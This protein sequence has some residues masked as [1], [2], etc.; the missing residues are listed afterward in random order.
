MY[1]IM[2]G[3]ISEERKVNWKNTSVK[4]EE[5][6]D[7]IIFRCK[8]RMST[9]S[10]AA[11]SFRNEVQLDWGSFAW[12][13]RKKELLKFFKKYGYPKELLSDLDTVKTY[14]VVYVDH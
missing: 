1:E 6:L 9:L 13:A 3:E 2:V 14:G 10:S 5:V 4:P 11:D 12:K 8:C 7:K